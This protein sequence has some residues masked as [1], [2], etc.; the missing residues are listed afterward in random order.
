[1]NIK[2]EEYQY[3]VLE[4]RKIIF[5]TNNG[6]AVLDFLTEKN[7]FKRT[8]KIG[9]FIKEYI[10]NIKFFKFLFQE[11]LILIFQL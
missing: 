1:M 8:T 6:A 11:I 9:D 7:I 2:A 5:P 3:P 10:F 4:L